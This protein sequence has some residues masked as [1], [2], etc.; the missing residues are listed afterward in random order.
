MSWDWIKARKNLREDPAV[1]AMSC[2]TGLEEDHVVGK[3]VRLWAWADDQTVDG[4]VPAVTEEWIDR[5]LGVNGFAAAMSKAGWLQCTAAGVEFPNFDR[6]NGVSAKRR[7]LD[8]ARKRQSR[9][10]KQP[11]QKRTTNGQGK[12]KTETVAFPPPLNTQRF[13]EVWEK[14][15]RF[16]REKGSPLKPTTVELQLKK[17]AVLGESGAIECVMFSMSQGY[18]GLFPEKV[19]GTNASGGMGQGGRINAQ[20]GKYANV[21]IRCGPEAE[22]NGHGAT[23]AKDTKGAGPDTPLFA[24]DDPQAGQR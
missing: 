19:N 14:W 11:D 4:L 3:L 5:H 23:P 18:T 2:A 24:S 9:S 7:A 16:R 12:D 10:A 6:H 8:A 15:V 20:P 22:S 1:I 13:A 21:G 17:L